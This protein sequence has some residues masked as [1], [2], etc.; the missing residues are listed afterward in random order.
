MQSFPLETSH[1]PVNRRTAIFF[2]VAS[3]MA[4]GVAGAFAD[5][6]TGTTGN[7]VPVEN[8]QPTLVVRYIIALQGM[9]P[10]DAQ[11]TPTQQV[12][13]DRTYQFI[14]EIKAVP[15]D[16]AP[17]GWTFCEGQLLQINQNQALFSLLST[18]YGGNG[19]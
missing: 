13:P 7:S 4:G 10:D 3:T 18:T 2:I 19:I 1:R 15:F 17:G 11:S 16:F 14:G 12:A 9:F 8:R 5:N 6:V